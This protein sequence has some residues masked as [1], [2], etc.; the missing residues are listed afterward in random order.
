MINSNAGSDGDPNVSYSISINR[1]SD[2]AT[3]A[4]D[5]SVFSPK[6]LLP[7]NPKMKKKYEVVQ[8]QI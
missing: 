4:R 5:I 7:N 1:L 8:L 6:A 2:E 3:R